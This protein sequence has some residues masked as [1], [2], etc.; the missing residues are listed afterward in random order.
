MERA[1]KLVRKNIYSNKVL[2]DDD[3]AR[4][5]W[6]SAVGRTIAAHTARVKLVRTKLVVEV[7]DAIWQRQLYP[8]SG[9]ILEQIRRV[10]ESDLVQDIEFRI[11]VPRRQAA[12]AERREGEGGGTQAVPDEAET[13]RD[14][15]LKK[16]YRLSRKKATA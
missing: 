12:R 15:V 14:P 9:Q 10:T 13:I 3:F 4:A 11:G 7:E 2:T 5:I 16:V 1:A 6:P 8:L